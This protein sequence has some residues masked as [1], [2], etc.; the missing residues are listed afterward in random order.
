MFCSA[1]KRRGLA[2]GWSRHDSNE[3]LLPIRNCGNQ[4][5]SDAEGPD[6]I[7]SDGGRSVAEFSD[8][9]A[10]KTSEIEAA[11]DSKSCGSIDPSN[12]RQEFW[13]TRACPSDLQWL[14]RS[15][16]KL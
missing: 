4:K 14:Y 15:R 11:S 5:R 1:A 16:R 13:R 10:H 6:R 2:W 12:S 7:F 9:G 8:P 3:N